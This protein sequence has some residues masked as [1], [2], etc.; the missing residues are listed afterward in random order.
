MC[1][2]RIKGDEIA[3]THD[4]MSMMI[5]ADRRGVTV[6]LHILEGRRHDPLNA[7]A[8]HHPESR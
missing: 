2:D 5:S 3:L 7:R 4:F 6:N 1:H 8:R